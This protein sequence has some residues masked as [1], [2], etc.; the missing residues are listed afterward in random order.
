MKNEIIAFI[1]AG[2]MSSSIIGGL[3]K[4]GHP[5]ENIIASNPHPEKCDQL[6]TAFAIKTTTDNIAAVAA[7][8]VVV[9]GVKPKSLI[10]LCKELTTTI[11]KNKPLVLSIAAGVSEKSIEAQLGRDIA[12]VRVMPNTPSLIGCGASALYPN[13]VVSVKQHDLAESIMRAVG[14][15]IWVKNEDEIDTVTALSGSGPAYFFLI[16]ES[17]QQAAEELGL[18]S[19][20][21]KLLTLQTALGASRLA[22][23]SDDSLETLRQR[24]TSPGGTTEKGIAALENAH[25]R[26]ILKKTL[27]A[28]KD[29]SKEL[30]VEFGEQS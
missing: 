29:R 1:G 24:V 12:I 22:L 8:D 7:A 26:D 4:D 21:A 20:D 30:A 2:N 11:Q 3:I 28:A 17:L 19:N 9:L 13:R 16:M 27:I 6:E 15:V 18:S 5:K 10:P 23:E 25:I 14:V